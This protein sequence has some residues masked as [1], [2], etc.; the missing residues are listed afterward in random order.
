MNNSSSCLTAIYSS[1]A[2]KK[3]G[4]G[5]LHVPRFHSIYRRQE[6]RSKSAPNW[7]VCDLCPWRDTVFN[8]TVEL[9]RISQ[10]D[11]LRGMGG[12]LGVGRWWASRVRA[13]VVI[14]KAWMWQR[15][16]VRWE[17]HSGVPGLPRGCSL[18]A[19]KHLPEPTSCRVHGLAHYMT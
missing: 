15:S 5:F 3:R 12:I 10:L 17:W 11:V 7:A 14:S 1:P 6:N 13:P 19:V 9:L 2:E 18:I 4:R 16:V 8:G